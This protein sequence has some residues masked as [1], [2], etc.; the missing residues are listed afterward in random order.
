MKTDYHD[1]SIESVGTTDTKD[2]IN[3][4]NNSTAETPVLFMSGFG[5]RAQDYYEALTHLHTK[6]GRRVIAWNKITGAQIPDIHNHPHKHILTTNLSQI[7]ASLEVLKFAD[8]HKHK[9]DIL[10]HS[11][12]AIHAVRL[13]LLHPE[14]IGKIVM[15][16]PAGIVANEGKGNLGM[17]ILKEAA[18]T[19][20]QPKLMINPGKQKRFLY[21]GRLTGLE[22]KTLLKS[23]S[24]ISKTDLLPL[25][26]E[27][28]KIHEIPVTLVAGAEDKLFDYRLTEERL[29]EKG[30]CDIDTHEHFVTIPGNHEGVF[31]DL[32]IFE[33]IIEE[34]E[35]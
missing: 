9:V 15:V 2:V 21:N 28:K 23:F 32:G 17:S 35:K 19:I 3:I 1:L 13:A 11:E 22:V 7:I 26:V 24:T 33:K 14:Y 12:G 20:T 10:A 34:L 5:R 27:L 18:N 4:N 8:L 25:L 16:N 30:S 31:D 29:T 6:T